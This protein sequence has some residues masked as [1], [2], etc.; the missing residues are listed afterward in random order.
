[1][2]QN[3]PSIT[4]LND[5]KLVISWKSSHGQDGDGDGIFAQ[6]FEI[7]Y[8]GITYEYDGSDGIENISGTSGFDS[9]ILTGYK[10]LAPWGD[11]LEMVT[12]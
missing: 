2:H 7:P 6:V 1:M 11:R 12:T 8:S 5:G 9:N 4:T 10:E 3:I